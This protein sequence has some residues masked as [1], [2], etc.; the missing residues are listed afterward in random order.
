MLE[1]GSL[2]VL[3][4]DGLG[5]LVHSVEEPSPLAPEEIRVAVSAV[6]LNFRDSYFIRGNQF[7]G[8]DQGRVPLSDAVGV[9]TEVG[10]SAQKYRLGARVLSTVLPHWQ[11]GPLTAESLLESPGSR[12]KDGVLRSLVTFRED[13]V[14]AAPDYLTDVE[15]ATLP[16][17]ALTAWH[18]LAEQH[19][20]SPGGTVVIQTT[21]GVALFALQIAQRLGLRTIVVSRSTE[22]LSHALRVGADAVINTTDTP[23]WE[24]R[25]LDVTDARGADLVL[26]MGLTD[27]LRRSVR[28]ASYE[29]TVAIIG[30]VQEQTNPLDIFPVMNKN[31]IVRG[32]ETGSRAMFERMNA[33]FLQ[34]QIHPVIDSVFGIRE[35]DRA[36]DRLEQSPFGKIAVAL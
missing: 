36:L 5:G 9:V 20:V 2:S 16:V 26:D 25:V 7:R 29:G 6:S 17:A 31:V 32:V 1:F 35:L 19:S 30:V 15:A 4:T 14:V 21:G 8:P 34:H 3:R 18:A 24:E 10:A 22:K 28:A 23:E 27:S 11:D 33:F 12:K 13:A